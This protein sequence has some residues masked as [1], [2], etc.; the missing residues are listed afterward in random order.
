MPS[1]V[2]LAL[3]IDGLPKSGC[4]RILA[5]VDGFDLV[6]PILTFSHAPTMLFH[7]EHCSLFNLGAVRSQLRSALE[8]PLPCTG[9]L[10]WSALCRTNSFQGSPPGA[11][12]LMNSLARRAS[13][14]DLG[15]VTPS[16][17]RVVGR[18]NVS[19]LTLARV[20]ASLP[21]HM[22]F[23]MTPSPGST[24]WDSSSS[25][26]PGTK[27]MRVGPG[28]PPRSYPPRRASCGSN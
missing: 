23:L 24:F 3:R 4:L 20:G 2:S 7:I 16:P 21:P 26:P 5:V 10:V 17:P 11:S 8:G 27:G 22:K 28:W 6:R 14:W 13:D 1:G 25:R 9:S 19:H 15:S 18:A 12:P